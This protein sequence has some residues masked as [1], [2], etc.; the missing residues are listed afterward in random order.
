MFW[1]VPILQQ[2][3]KIKLYLETVEKRA[4]RTQKMIKTGDKRYAAEYDILLKLKA[5]LELGKPARACEVSADDAEFVKSLFLLTTKP[6]IYVANIAEDEIGGAD[7]PFVNALRDSV[8][9]QNAEVLVISA[10]VEEE[11]AGLDPEEKAAFIEELGIGESGLDKLALACY[12]LLGLMSYLTAG[13][14]EVRAWTIEIG[15]KAPQA[16]GKI[17]SDFERGFIRAEVIGYDTLIEA[18]SM[19]TAREKGLVRSEGKDYVMRDG[20]IVLFRFNV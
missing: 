9:N 1:G 16:A 12:R 19:Q 3:D 13:P 14:K 7:N 18:G 17:H 5:T 6:V 15:T 8:R 20:D 11:I 4:E 10:K 2:S